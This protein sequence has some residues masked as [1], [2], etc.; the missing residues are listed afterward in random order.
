M[1]LLLVAQVLLWLGIGF[2]VIITWVVLTRLFRADDY[3]VEEFLFNLNYLLP[4][5]LYI[6][7]FVTHYLATVPH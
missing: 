7:A 1:N 5:T 3:P 2:T 4:I 6:A